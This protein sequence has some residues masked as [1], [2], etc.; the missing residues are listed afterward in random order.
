ML[1]KEKE[2]ASQLSF[3]PENSSINTTKEFIT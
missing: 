2:I 3:L 1:V